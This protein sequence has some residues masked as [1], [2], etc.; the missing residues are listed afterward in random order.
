MSGEFRI[1]SECERDHHWA[2]VGHYSFHEDGELV[3]VVCGCPC[4]HRVGEKE[5]ER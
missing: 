3:M 2:C 5:D 1:F 4:H